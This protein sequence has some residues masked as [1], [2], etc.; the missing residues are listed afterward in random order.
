[1]RTFFCALLLSF[2]VAMPLSAQE[3][4]GNISGTVKDA[5]GVIPG[6]TV[7]IRSIDTGATQ[8]LVTNGSGYFEAPLMQPGNYQMT[9]EMT[10]FKR[11]VQSGIVLGVSQQ[12]NI[13]FVLE[14][15]TINET[16]TVTGEA[17]LI[18]TSSVSSSQTFDSKMVEALPMISNMPIMLTRYSDGV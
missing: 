8:Q 10:G 18:D 5:T 15:G 3:T 7:T 2:V 13:P 16:I 9:V 11:V 4:R 17:P 6:A 1:M 12:L 14:L